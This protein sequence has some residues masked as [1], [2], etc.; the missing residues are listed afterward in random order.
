MK[1]LVLFTAFLLFGFSLVGCGSLFTQTTTG[2]SIVT[3]APTYDEEDVED[4]ITVSDEIITFSNSGITSKNGNV[5]I[6]G[7]LVTISTGGTY[8]LSGTSS[9]ASIVISVSDN[10]QVTLILDNVNLT[11][12]NG[13]VINAISSDKLIVN[14]KEGTTNSF[15]DSASSTSDIKSC[16][17]SNDDITVNG[18]GSLTIESNYGNGINTDDDLVI[19]NGIVTIDA[20]NNALKANDSITICKATLDLTAGNDGIHCENTEDTTQ[21]LI[22]VE[23][24]TITIS[25]Y[26]D[27]MDAS[28]GVTLLDGTYTITSG[29]GN[30]SIA[31]VSGKGV[32]GTVFVEIANGTYTITSKDDAIHANDRCTIDNGSMIIKSSDD[33]IHADTLLTINGGSIDIQ[34]SYEG[35]ESIKIV[36]NGGSLGIVSTDDGMNAAGG[37]DGSGTF[38]WG[39]VPG[40]S[41]GNASI[42]I[43]GGS[44]YVNAK[45]DGVDANGS[46]SMSGG[47]VIVSG[48]TDNGN[49][50]LDYDSTF[51]IT[52][53]LFVASGSS[54]MAQNVSNSSTQCGALIFFSSATT[55]LIRIED[56][57][58]NAVLTFKPE[59]NY[60]SLVISSP[61]L[62]K[63][64]T[65]RVYTGGSVAS[66]D[67]LAHG[68][69]TNATYV[70]GTLFTTF[71]ISAIATQIGSGGGGGRP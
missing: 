35:L 26:G 2:S 16:I 4:V 47:T 15:T 31:T 12:T 38:G 55:N 20:K 10:V 11:S 34:K 42:T 17:F 67:S 46:I 70:Q 8:I 71:A 32:K 57:A 41:S 22:I 61:S 6:D 36:V 21:G 59:K 54:G 24:G 29:V 49:G 23:N 37:N 1:K 48:P 53:G 56:E 64:S 19:T 5:E 43:S 27:G 68:F 33:G 40:A 69:Y 65:Y 44:V 52:G 14:I 62:L 50:P 18:A 39:G 3:T 51:N 13:P 30:T 45:G 63:G 25:A 66:Y 9:D 7:S 60:Q 28:N 58:G